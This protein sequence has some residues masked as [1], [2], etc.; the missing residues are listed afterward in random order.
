M[1]QKS[2]VLKWKKVMNVQREEGTLNQ[3]NG[4]TL[5]MDGVQTTGK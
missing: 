3:K 1:K 5:K 4:M 2:G